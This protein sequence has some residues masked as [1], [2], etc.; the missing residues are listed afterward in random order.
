MLLRAQLRETAIAA[1]KAA[2]TM[3]LNQVFSPRDWPTNSSNYPCV[4]VRASRDSKVSANKGMPQFTT[5][6]TLSVIGRVE[7][8]S[9]CKAEDLIE[10]FADQLENAILTNYALITAVQCVAS[11]TSSSQVTAEG[12]R[13]IGEVQIDFDLEAF[14]VFDLVD[15]APAAVQPV[16]VPLNTLDIHADLAGTFDATGTY[17]N[18]PFPAA[19]LPA[20]RT[21][22]PDGRDEGA[23]QITLSS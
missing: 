8:K 6:V 23:L 17:A 16:A 22:G 20:P 21:S 4:L 18:P 7:D 13:H 14:E 19:V 11:V 15:D 3:A 12:E 2:Q 5:T 10:E 1:V 9:E